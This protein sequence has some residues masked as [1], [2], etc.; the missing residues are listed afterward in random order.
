MIRTGGRVLGIK[1]MGT[2]YHWAFD[3]GCVAEVL[4]VKSLTVKFFFFFPPLY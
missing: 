3:L 1:T 4:L 2:G